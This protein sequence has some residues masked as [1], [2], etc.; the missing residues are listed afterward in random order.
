MQ[1][2]G[3]HPNS[4]Q[5]KLSEWKGHSQGVTNLHLSNVHFVLRDVV[6]LFGPSWGSWLPTLIYLV[7]E[8]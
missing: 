7:R 3:N 2:P 6:A 4:K 5:K 8:Q 1:K